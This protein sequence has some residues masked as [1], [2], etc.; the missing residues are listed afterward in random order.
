ML[1]KRELTLKKINNLI[2]Y[3]L[4]KRFIR[5]LLVGGINTIVGYGTFAIFIY[6]NYHYYFSYIMSYVIGIANSYIWNKLFTFKSKNKSYRELLRFISV[7]LISFV[8][9]SIFLYTAVD[10]LKINEYVAGLINLIFVT[11]I[12]WIGHNKFSFKEQ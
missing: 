1:R 6:F 5:F 3:Y 11:L 2:K 7:Y 8:I 4:E 10:M 12:S 9:G